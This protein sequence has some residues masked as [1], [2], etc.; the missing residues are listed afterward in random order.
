MV[1]FIIRVMD[2]WADSLTQEQF[3]NRLMVVIGIVF[4]LILG[5]VGTMEYNDLRR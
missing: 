2:K 4:F 3:D 1:R 5:I